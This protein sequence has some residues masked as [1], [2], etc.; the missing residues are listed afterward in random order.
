MGRVDPL[1]NKHNNIIVIDFR[2]FY[3][4]SY[5]MSVISNT[6]VDRYTLHRDGVSLIVKCCLRWIST[7]D[8]GGLGKDFRLYR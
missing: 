3:C 7:V 6:Y 4:E 2:G 8:L 5:C 1:V